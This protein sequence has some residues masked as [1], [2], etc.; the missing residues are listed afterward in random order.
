MPSIVLLG[1]PALSS[2][3]ALRLRTRCVSIHYASESQKD[4]AGAST[5]FEVD[6][7]WASG[8]T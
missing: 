5:E 2:A 1:G 3:S 8:A 6:Q 7:T 4:L